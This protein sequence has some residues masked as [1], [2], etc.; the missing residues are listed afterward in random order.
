MIKIVASRIAVDN[1]D[2]LNIFEV[3]VLSPE[4][5]SVFISTLA[6]QL[7]NQLIHLHRL[8]I[9]SKAFGSDVNSM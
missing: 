2:V 9:P 8:D 6:S 3:F 1:A 4:S 7:S 5:I